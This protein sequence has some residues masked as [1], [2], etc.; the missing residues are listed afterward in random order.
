VA[1]FSETCLATT[2]KLWVADCLCMLA[3][4]F[5]NESVGD[6]LSSHSPSWINAT[7]ANASDGFI[8]Q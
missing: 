1:W 4:D 7:V 6:L 2:V 3:L 8:G 5:A